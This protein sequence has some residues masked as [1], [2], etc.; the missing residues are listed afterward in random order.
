MDTGEKDDAMWSLAS[1]KAFSG[2]RGGSVNAALFPAHRPMR[3]SL[4]LP[5]VFDHINPNMN[6]GTCPFAAG[7]SAR[8]DV[9]G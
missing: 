6:D 9:A 8:R 1:L 3:K 7:R 5:P 2:R 4:G